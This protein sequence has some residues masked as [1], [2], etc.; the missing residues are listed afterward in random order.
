MNTTRRAVDLALLAAL[1]GLASAPVFPAAPK[2]N[3]VFGINCFDLFYALL[4]LQVRNKDPLTRLRKLSSIRVPYVRFCASG[5]WP[6]EWKLYLDDEA[7]Y[8]RRMDKVFSAAEKTGIKLIP[9]LFFNASTVSDIVN[10]PVSYWGRADSKTRHFSEAYTRKFVARYRKSKVVLMWEFSN[11]FNTFVDMPNALNW[12]PKVSPSTGTP[13]SRNQQDMLN[14]SVVRNAYIAFG[15]LVQELDPGVLISSGGD[16]PQFNAHNLAKKRFDVDTQEAFAENLAFI[17]PPPL[18][19]ISVH[20]YPDRK[21]RA[22]GGVKMY[23]SLLDP[24]V[25]VA[26]KNNQKVFVG[27]FGAP[28]TA[29]SGMSEFW[30][31]VTAIKFAGVDFAALWN[32]DN[33]AQIEWNIDFE[34]QRSYQLEI[35]AKDNG[36]LDL[37]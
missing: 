8:W 19:T 2:K 34:N 33:A 29:P 12:W 32:Y 35:F 36:K 26:H 17:N 9:S 14:R 28:G 22:F 30:D 16:F 23:R 7:E 21:K 27:E 4:F 10:E 37:R 24:V 3:T 1:T 11:E 13:R 6:N 15:N 31:L 18:S 25:E 20:I 5:F